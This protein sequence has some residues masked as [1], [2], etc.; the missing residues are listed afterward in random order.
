MRKV[1]FFIIPILNYN[2]SGYR[3]ISNLNV[4]KWN[5]DASSMKEASLSIQLPVGY[6]GMMGIL[7]I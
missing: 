4:A 5:V 1:F 3:I 2:L 7:E 6:E